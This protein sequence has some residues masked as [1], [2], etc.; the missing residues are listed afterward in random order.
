MFLGMYVSFLIA[1]TCFY[2]HPDNI[3]SRFGLGVGSLF[4][5]IGNKYIIDSSLPDSTS[6]TLVDTLHGITLF[7]IF[8]VITSS[9]LS[10]MLIK[11]DKLQQARRINLVLAQVVLLVYVALNVYF[12]MK[13]SNG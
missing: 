1:Y 12:I 7:F 13:A 5:A 11:A 9:A 10:L 2:I 4:A 3:D 6:F 8:A